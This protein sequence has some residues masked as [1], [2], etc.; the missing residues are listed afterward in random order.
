[1][2]RPPAP[3]LGPA[4]PVR[5]HAAVTPALPSGCAA[6]TQPDAFVPCVCLC[7]SPI[8][9]H[10]VARGV[11]SSSGR[12]L[13]RPGGPPPNPTHALHSRLSHDRFAVSASRNPST[14][15]FLDVLHE[16]P[17]LHLLDSALCSQARSLP[18]ALPN[19][20]SIAR[21]RH[22]AD[23]GRSVAAYSLGNSADLQHRLSATRRPRLPARSGR[24]GPGR[25]LT[26]R[27]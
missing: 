3:P 6:S 21:P 15:D 26:G 12:Y 9:S 2:D 19:R 24:H 4:P 5:A 10:Q 7:L 11:L 22:C 16:Q 25:R 8:A 20:L 27:A 13:Y 23:P 18:P 14:P 1:M 17:P